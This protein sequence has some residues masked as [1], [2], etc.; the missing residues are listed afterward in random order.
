MIVG[1]QHGD[2]PVTRRA[3]VGFS[4][5]RC[6]HRVGYRRGHKEAGELVT[7]EHRKWPTSPNLIGGPWCEYV[8]TYDLQGTP[9]EIG[10]KAEP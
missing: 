7:V 4:V 6:K 8:A 3:T 2:F 9:V 10:R 1:T 5:V